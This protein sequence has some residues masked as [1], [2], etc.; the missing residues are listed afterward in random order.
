MNSDV[1]RTGRPVLLYVITDSVST[2]F[3]CGQ[4]RAVIVSGFDVHLATNFRGS[5]PQVDE[6]VVLHNIDM[7]RAPHLTRDLRSLLKMLRLVRSLRPDVVNVSTPKAALIG[8]AA[9]F[10]ARVPVRIYV[11]RG[12]RA[13]TATGIGRWLVLNL[14]RASALLAT[15]MICNSSSL[16][17]LAIKLKF[18]HARDAIMLGGGSSNGVD[19]SRFSP[20]VPRSI[21][22]NPLVIGYV[23]RLARDKGVIDL[24]AAFDQVSKHLDVRLLIIGSEDPTDPLPQ[25]VLNRLGGDHAITRIDWMTDT[26]TSY[27]EFDVLAFPSYREGLPNVPLEAQASGVPVVGYAATGTVDAVLDGVSGLLVPV[28]DVDSLASALADLL[29]DQERRVR[30]GRAGR[31]WVTEHFSQERVWTDLCSALARWHLRDRRSSV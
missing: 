2:R 29:T 31:S 28:G 27:A 25:D 19:I 12:I 8:G 15:H 4:L 24:L 30:M 1:Q 16:R 6:G 22:R 10:V 18:P 14:E 5:Q 7:E 17:A 9:A 20:G 26:S 23:G 13:E 3:L 21:Q 11:M